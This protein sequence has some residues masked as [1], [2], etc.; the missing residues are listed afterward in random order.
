M[1]RTGWSRAYRHTTRGRA[2]SLHGAAKKRAKEK[3]LDFDITIDWVEQRLITGVCEVTG[4]PFEKDDAVERV[5]RSFAPSLD[6]RDNALGY[7][8]D[9]VQVVCWIYNR[10]KGVQ[11]AEDVLRM[12][13]A[14]CL[15]Q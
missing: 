3:G 9:N 2:I 10:A 11:G 4:I 12:A 14:L 7:T 15:S 6:R 1:D 8:Q 13:E 5:G